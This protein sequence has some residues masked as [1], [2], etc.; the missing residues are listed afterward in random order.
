MP[1]MTTTSAA[2]PPSGI[3]LGDGITDPANAA[4]VDLANG[5]LEMLRSGA[6]GQWQAK[7]NALPA[8]LQIVLDTSGSMGEA[9]R[10]NGMRG[11]ATKW[12]STVP[13]LTSASNSLSGRF[14]SSHDLHIGD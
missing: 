9:P 7:T 14:S 12:V 5:G 4:P 3:D 13:A 11:A 2:L 10:N 1:S 8:V 6:C